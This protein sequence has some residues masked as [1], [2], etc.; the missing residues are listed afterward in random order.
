MLIMT[1]EVCLCCSW[2][3]VF[4]SKSWVPLTLGCRCGQTRKFSCCSWDRK[5]SNRFL[6]ATPGSTISG[7]LMWRAFSSNG[8]KIFNKDL[9]SRKFNKWCKS[10]FGRARG[11]GVTVIGWAIY[12][13]S[14]FSSPPSSLVVTLLLLTYPLFIN[15][16]KA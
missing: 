8:G 11:G 2:D 14:P 4:T 6:E 3:G 13:P 10:V 12:Q 16:P 5:R 7:K 15:P 1:M 9:F